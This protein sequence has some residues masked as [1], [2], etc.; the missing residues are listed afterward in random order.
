MKPTSRAV[1]ALVRGG[2]TTGQPLPHH[3][4]DYEIHDPGE[5]GDLLAAW[6][7]DTG[8]G[9]PLVCACSGLEGIVTLY[10]ASGQSVR[11]LALSRAEPLAHLLGSA[12]EGI[13]ARHPKRRRVPDTARDLLLRY[14]RSHRPADLA[15]LERRLLRAPDD[16]VRR[17]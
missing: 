9:G 17:S 16:R 13:P 15:V 12:A 4:G 11:T 6:P 2:R 8:S 10:E 5:I 14:A 7:R 3:P 1:R